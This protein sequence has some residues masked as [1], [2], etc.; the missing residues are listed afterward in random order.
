MINKQAGLDLHQIILDRTITREL[1]LRKPI[2]KLRKITI[3]LDQYLCSTCLSLTGTLFDC[4][5][6]L[7]L[8]YG[9]LSVYL[10][11]VKVCDKQAKDNLSLS[12]PIVAKQNVHWKK[13]IMSFGKKYLT[14]DANI[15]PE[16]FHLKWQHHRPF[17]VQGF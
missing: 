13:R 15:L 2:K 5:L 3:L 6:H 9:L 7:V 16:I 8:T 10:D 12:L 1:K 11:I 4:E 14:L 17:F